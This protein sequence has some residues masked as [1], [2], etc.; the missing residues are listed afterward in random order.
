MVATPTKTKPTPL[1]LLPWFAVIACVGSSFFNANVIIPFVPFLVH[2]L[3]PDYTK[4]QLGYRTGFLDAAFFIGVMIGG[5]LWGNASDRFGRKNCLLLGVLSSTIWALCFGMCENYWLALAI[6]LCWGFCGA[7]LSISRSILGEISDH[8]NRARAFTAVGLGN[9]SGRLLG[10]SVGGLLSEPSDKYGLFKNVEFFKSHPYALPVFISA[11]LNMASLIFAACF[12]PE[13]KPRLRPLKSPAINNE[14]L[15][16]PLTLPGIQR[17]ESDRFQRQTLHLGQD[18]NSYLV[19]FDS[20]KLRRDPVD[21]STEP[22]R[23]RKSTTGTEDSALEKQKRGCCWICKEVPSLKLLLAAC[24][25]VSISHSAYNA[26]YPLW[27]LNDPEHHGF[28]FRTTGIGLSR[29][30]AVPTDLILQLV[31]FPWAVRKFGL[32]PCYY[33]AGSLWV[34]I[35][36]ATPTASY[37][38]TCSNWVQYLVL[39]GVVVLNNIVAAITLSSNGIVFSNAAEKENRGKVMGIRQSFLGFGRGS[40]SI[41]GGIIFAWSLKNEERS[42]FISQ[43]PFNHYLIWIIQALLLL[44][45]VTFAVQLPRTLE[46]TPAEWRKAR[47]EE[48]ERIARESRENDGARRPEGGQGATTRYSRLVEPQLPGE[49]EGEQGVRS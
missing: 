39:Y 30:A 1:P 41:L 34:A 33:G 49:R 6:R 27:V 42:G 11:G 17:E 18:P 43:F 22:S 38:N 47:A 3:Y 26:V 29:L 7:N 31:F 19:S 10:N 24:L 40:G 46:R 20:P 25:C 35:V 8:T 23:P 36:L 4:T 32:L 13:T 48:E 45:L 28:G 5:P 15:T 16:Q 21:Q 12:L 9:I 37:A 44:G 2:H 14:Q